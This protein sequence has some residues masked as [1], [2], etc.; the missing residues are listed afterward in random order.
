MA[1]ESI[2]SY[3]QDFIPDSFS[4]RSKILAGR[5]LKL[6]FG[7]RNDTCKLLQDIDGKEFKV[8]CWERAE[9]GGGIA[10]C[11]YEGNKFLN[12]NVDLSVLHGHIPSQAVDQ[13]REAGRM[14]TAWQNEDPEFL[15]IAVSCII[16]TRNPHVPSY[17]FNQRLFVIRVSD[18]SEEGWFGGH[19]DLSPSYLVKEDVMNFHKTLKAACDEHD[20][21]YYPHFKKRCDEYFFIRHRGEARGVGGIFF[22]NLNFRDEKHFDFMQSCARAIL[23]AYQP[24]VKAH[25]DEPHSE[26][27]DTW[28]LLH[29]GRYIEFN[30]MYDNGTKFGLFISGFRIDTLFAS[31][32]ITAKWGYMLEPEPGSKEAELVDVLRRPRDWV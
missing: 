32:P 16:H 20:L 3:L 15:V 31:L 18:G 29:Y 8:D 22:D 13:L 19:M 10:S 7:V 14:S 26:Q 24:I 27:E 1:E 12:A 30:L 25:L 11:L 9:G 5:F 6:V 28:Q 4:Q 17:N 21:S 2:L 23:P